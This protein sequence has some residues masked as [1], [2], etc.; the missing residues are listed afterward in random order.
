MEL[1]RSFV[2]LFYDDFME[3]IKLIIEI[4]KMGVIG[5]LYN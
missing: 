3:N 1:Y 5:C 4:N 2:I